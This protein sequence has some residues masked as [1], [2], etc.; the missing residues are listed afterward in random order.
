MPAPAIIWIHGDC[1]SPRNPIW[2][3]YP[4]VPAVWVWDEELLQAWGISFKRLVFIYECL[5]EL[6]LEIRRGNVIAELNCFIQAHQA[7]EVIT[8]PSPSPR[9]QAI[10]QGL[11]VP[12]RLIV[13]P[14]FV[15]LPENPDLKRFSRYW[16]VAKPQLLQEFGNLRR[17]S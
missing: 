17:L 11:S 12:V 1:L 7:H 9:F 3:E 16:N 14:E 5:V 13:L 8:N 2:A 10:C 4:R 15:K 6:P